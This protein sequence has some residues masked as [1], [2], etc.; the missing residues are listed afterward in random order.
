MPTDE[1]SHANVPYF[2]GY[3]YSSAV[4]GRD[5]VREF[6]DACRAAGIKPG[7]Y[8]NLGQ[9]FFCDVGA[10]SNSHSVLPTGRFQSCWDPQGFDEPLRPGQARVT[11]QQ[12]LEVARTLLQEL[13]GGTFGNDLAELWLDGGYP[14]QLAGFVSDLVDRHQPGA[15]VFQGPNYETSG[16]AV[17]WAGTESGHT[18]STDMWSTVDAAD[19]GPEGNFGYGAGTPGGSVFMPAEQDAA[20]Q[21]GQNAGGFWYPNETSKSVG[22]LLSEYEDSVGHNANYMLELSPDPRGALPAGDVKAYTAFGEALDRCYR[23]GGHGVVA[24]TSGAGNELV[25]PRWTGAT[26][27]RVRIAEAGTTRRVRKYEVLAATG[28]GGVWTV[29]AGGESVGRC[30]IHRLAKALPPGTRLKL[31]VTDAIA[32]PEFRT[33]EVLNI[34]GEKGCMTSTSQQ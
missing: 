22:E 11:L 25:L 23:D 16:N 29:V 6:V 18:P 17:R 12:Y 19:A 20:I 31:A 24:R 1:F 32:E 33:F 26:V 8:V 15:V 28:T 7:L 10:N 3:N 21:G 9:N 4:A 14:E 30:R 34:F 5:V 13:L 2:S 27:D